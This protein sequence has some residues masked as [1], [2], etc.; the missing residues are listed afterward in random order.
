MSDYSLTTEQRIAR[1]SGHLAAATHCLS[2][3][4]Q[5]MAAVSLSHA[6]EWIDS[7]STF[8]GYYLPS[9]VRQRGQALVRALAGLLPPE[10]RG[11]FTNY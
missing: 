8:G 1:I 4:C 6:D 11:R 10:Q 5:T 9:A 3:D 7:R 2:A